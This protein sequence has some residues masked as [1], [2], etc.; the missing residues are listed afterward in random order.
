MA[1]LGFNAARLTFF[2]GFGLAGCAAGIF[3]SAA[4]A[5]RIGRRRALGVV[6]CL[7]AA[8]ALAMAV[9]REGPVLL[10]A[11]F[12]GMINGMGRDRAAGHTLDQAMLPALTSA[13]ERTQTFAWYSLCV[14]VGNAAGAL[15]A[16]LPVALRQSGG[17]SLLGSYRATWVFYAA[18]CL[19]AAMLTTRLSS[20]VE[21]HLPKAERRLSSQTKPR[22]L[23]FA[24][25]S[26]LDSFGGGFLSTALISYWFFQRFGVSETFLAPLFFASRLANG[27]SHLGA[28]WLAKRIG[29]VRTMVFTHLP[30]SLLLIS[31]PFAPS[32]TVAVMLFLIRETLVEM[33]LPTRQSYL[34][35]I[36]GEGERTAAAAMTNGARSLSWASGPLLAGP[37]IQAAGVSAPL[38]LG[39]CLKIV[40]DL[41]LYR[42][43]R[44][45][46]PT[47]EDPS[48]T[49]T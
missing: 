41:L 5:E 44:L 24:A 20:A 11:A 30:S 9:A 31:V 13:K 39:A 19:I 45:L 6:L 17:M 4:L 29:L 49:A 12:L 10:G 22:V 15:L 7:M 23:R 2:V 16:L 40:Y 25:L 18:L 37:L 33:D 42:S 47:E 28:A 26:G 43:F 32:L 48:R 8:G 34:M 1:A 14:D 38:Y 27:L 46:R 3:W 36:V 21:T 35:A